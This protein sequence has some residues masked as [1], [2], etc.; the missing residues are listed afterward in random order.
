MDNQ[1]HLSE[2]LDLVTNLM[3]QI[4]GI[5]Y[6][7]K[8]K[9]LLYHRFVLSKISWHFT[10][11]D[12]RKTWVVENIDN[13][14]A[15][16]IRQWLELPISVTLSTLIL[17]KSKYGINFF[18]PSTKFLLC[19]TVKRNAL[20]SSPNSDI[21]L[22]WT[23]TSFGCNIQYDQYKNTKQVLAAIQK[24]NESRITHEL[25]SEG[26]VISCILTHASS[27]LRSLW[28]MT[29]QGMPKNIFNFSIKYLNNTLATRNNL[30]K[31]SI[32]QSSACSFC[33]QTESLQHIVSSCKFYLEDG[34]YTWRHSSVLLYLAK[35]FS[36]FS[37]CLLY[38]NLPSFLSPSFITGDSLRPDLILITKNSTLYILELTLGFESNIQINSD[39]KASKY[40]S[41]I[42]DLKHAYFDVQ[43]V[44][45]P[46]STLGIMGRS[47]ESLLLMLEDLKLDKNAQKHII[48]KIINIAIR[49]SY[50]VFCRRNKSWTN[51]DLLDF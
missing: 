10:I 4:D 34:R 16:Y 19:Q 15:G 11:A 49:C 28:S 31:W 36:S 29:Q 40:S 12:L 41:I 43:F 48:R 44:N 13:L 7:P 37:D 18:L 30:C 6:H 5:P 2:I 20:K 46:M 35:T 3:K 1:N 38:A 45:L 22:L 32:S 50:Y 14:V 24:D 8:N 33:L 26:F 27:K 25:K 51:P 17:P 21:N 23:Q 9:L 47:S 42:L 39:R